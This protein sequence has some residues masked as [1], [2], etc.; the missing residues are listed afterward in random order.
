M[1][2][3]QTLS[4]AQGTKA[5]PQTLNS[6]KDLIGALVALQLLPLAHSGLSAFAY[7]VSSGSGLQPLS[8]V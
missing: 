8:R 7:V 5:P 2:L 1:T 6:L 4:N 3:E